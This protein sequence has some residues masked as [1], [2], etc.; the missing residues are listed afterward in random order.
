M[1]ASQPKIALCDEPYAHLDPASKKDVRNVVLQWLSENGITLIMV[2]HD[3]L[4]DFSCFDVVGAMRQ[5]SLEA[6][7]KPTALQDLLKGMNLSAES[8]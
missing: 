2:T 3:P 4:E 1:L 5:G 7:D 6:W 8:S